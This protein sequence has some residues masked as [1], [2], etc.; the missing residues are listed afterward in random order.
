MACVIKP[1]CREKARADEFLITASVSLLTIDLRKKKW[2]PHKLAVFWKK[3]KA[4][5][6]TK[7]VAWFGGIEN[8]DRGVHFWPEPDPV[9][10]KLTLLKNPQDEM[11]EYQEKQWNILICNVSRNGRHQLLATGCIDISNYITERPGKV[12]V[13]VTLKPAI[14]KVL[15]GKI[16]F[17]L[18]WAM[19]EDDL[20]HPTDQE[21]WE[22][23]MKEAQE[24]QARRKAEGKMAKHKS[25]RKGR[26]SKPGGSSGTDIATEEHKRKAKNGKPGGSCGTDIVAEENKMKVKNSKHG[27]LSGAD[28]AA[29]EDK[30]KAK[31]GKGGG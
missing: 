7:P 28:I 13:T 5:Y 4:K 14:K 26:K 24:E 21:I 19:H 30:R 29:E 18:S 16:E 27:C 12:D 17:E 22:E 31:T 25:S 20:S 8:G 6:S 10:S 2:Y 15:S 9:D 23:I 11:T 1:F 3:R